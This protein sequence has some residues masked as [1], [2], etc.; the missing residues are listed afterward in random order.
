MKDNIEC[1]VVL[2]TN[3]SMCVCVWGGGGGWGVGGGGGGGG[4]GGGGEI[5]LRASFVQITK[6][7]TNF[8]L[9][10]LFRNKD[11]ISQ[12]LKILNHRQEANTKLLL[13]LFLNLQTPS[14]V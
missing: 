3:I 9:A 14:R 13:N 7:Y 6:V 8:N 5:I 12:P 1:P 4:W 10:I 11:D 2:S